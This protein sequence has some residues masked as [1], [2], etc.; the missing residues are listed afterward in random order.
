MFGERPAENEAGVLTV[1]DVASKVFH[2]TIQSYGIKAGCG[3]ESGIIHM[4]FVKKV[5]KI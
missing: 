3:S 2:S 4:Y 1:E 5:K